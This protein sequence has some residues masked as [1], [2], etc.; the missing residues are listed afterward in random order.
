MRLSRGR[1]SSLVVFSAFVALHAFGC[2]TG[3]DAVTLSDVDAGGSTTKDAT[4]DHTTSPGVDSSMEDSP[5]FS[6]VD[7]PVAIDANEPTDGSAP[8]DAAADASKPEDANMPVDANEPVDANT[9]V[10][11]NEP[12]DS[13]VP[14]DANTPPN[15]ATKVA[16]APVLISGVPANGDNTGA[17]NDVPWGN[18]VTGLCKNG[19][20]QTGTT[21]DEGLP[22]QGPDVVYQIYVPANKTCYA[23]LDPMGNDLALALIYPSPSAITSAS[24][25]ENE[26]FEFDDEVG[27]ADS[28]GIQAGSGGFTIYLIVE[29]YAAQDQGAFTLTATIQ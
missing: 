26:C 7:A 14:V 28:V 23:T 3:E 24:L 27:N 22:Y 13:N 18:T 12:V 1:V 11:A 19:S 5:S 29:G 16:D 2:A 4:A 9:P 15:F 17:G 21:G 25:A 10:D 8:H 6:M 20:Y